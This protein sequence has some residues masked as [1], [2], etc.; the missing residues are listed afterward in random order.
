VV[1]TAKDTANAALFPRDL[2]D[3]E[4]VDP[5]SLA[6]PGARAETGAYSY[7]LLSLPLPRCSRRRR[8]DRLDEQ[9][10]PDHLRRNGRSLRSLVL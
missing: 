5:S 9:Q 7:S 3:R 10:L 6:R 4:C 1:G 8:H 2:V